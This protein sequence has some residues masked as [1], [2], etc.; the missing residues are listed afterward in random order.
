M[1]DDSDLPDKA[2]PVRFA[3]IRAHQDRDMDLLGKVKDNLYKSKTFHGAGKTFELIVSKHEK[4]VIPQ[5]LRQ[6]VLDWYHKFLMHPGRDRTEK[7]ISQHF[8]WKGMHKDIE[9]HCKKCKKCQ[10]SKKKHT[11]YGHLPPKEAEA[12][13][14]DKLCVDCIGPYK[15]PVNNKDK[16]FKKK[17]IR[18]LNCFTMIDPATG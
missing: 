16:P 17:D 8:Y 9:N 3:T 5:K 1:Q 7:T 2:M 18:T 14:W 12:I 15:I 10:L 6:K 13:P 11:K 4:I